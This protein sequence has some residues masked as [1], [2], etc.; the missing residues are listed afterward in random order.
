MTKIPPPPPGLR[1]SGR[2]LWTSIVDRH[3]LAVHESLVLVEACRIADRCD[4]LNDAI[5]KTKGIDKGLLVEARHQQITLTRL[6]A[7]LRIPEP[8]QTGKKPQ[9]NRPR[10]TYHEERN[11]PYE[12]T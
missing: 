6:I 1:A 5:N 7:S 8:G 12:N 9:R 2:A 3:D 10:G 4:A 11:V